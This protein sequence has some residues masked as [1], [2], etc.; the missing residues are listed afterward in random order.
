MLEGIHR[1]WHWRFQDKLKLIEGDFQKPEEENA[2]K[3]EVIFKTSIAKL[4]NEESS[5]DISQMQED[6]NMKKLNELSDLD[7]DVEESKMKKN[8]L[9]L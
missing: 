7:K 6:M 8:K 2:D 5:L 9:R 4:E 1:I 3:E